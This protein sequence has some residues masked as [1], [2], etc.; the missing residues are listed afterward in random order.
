MTTFDPPLVFE[1]IAIFDP[2]TPGPT[3]RP[4][5]A[6]TFVANMFTVETAF[7]TKMFPVTLR[8]V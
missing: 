5:L 8:E 6:K 2:I 3:T 1:K 4:V 7:D